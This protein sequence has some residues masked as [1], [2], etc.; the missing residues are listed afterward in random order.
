MKMSF[1]P[2]YMPPIMP[3]MVPGGALPPMNQPPPNF[4]PI[5]ATT[6]GSQPQM[7]PKPLP[8]PQQ[9][10]PEGPLITVFVGNISEKVP[11]TM[12]KRILDTCGTVIN[13]KR[14]STFGFCEYDGPIAG[15]RGVRLLNDLEIDG[16]KLVAKV[17]AKNK[18]LLDDYMEETKKDATQATLDANA[19]TERKDDT[20]ATDTIQQIIEEYADQIKKAAN[21]NEPHHK[22]HKPLATANIEEEKRDIISQEIGKFR[23]YTEEMEAKKEERKR[24]EEARQE[25]KDKDKDKEKEKQVTEE[26]SPGKRDKEKK[27]K[28]RS[29]SRSRGSKSPARS[30]KER[31]R[32]RSHSR[33]REREVERERREREI[34]RERRE[35]ELERER[36]ERELDAPPKV[37]KNLKELQRE[38]EIEEEAR[39][40]KKQEKKTR[41]KEAAYQDRLRNWES[42]ERRKTKEY[43]RE[44]ETARCKEEEREK[45]AKRLKEFLE[46][47]EDERDDPKYYKG[48]ELQR[49]LADRV[50]EA[51][52]DAKDRQREQEELEELKAKIFSG[53][54]DNPSLEFEKQKK[55]REELYK[56]KILVDANPETQHERELQREKERIADKLRAK[57]RKERYLNQQMSRNLEGMDAEPIES[58]DDAAV[59]PPQPLNSNNH[60]PKQD[61]DSRI[62]SH[63]GS[64]S[65]D[66]H[67]HHDADSRHSMESG[68]TPSESPRNTPNA[69]LPTFQVSLS[70][71]TNAKKKKLVSDVFQNDDD[72][73]EMN[74]PK[75]RKLVPLD[76]DEN[77][78]SKHAVVNT[79]A[80]AK[81][82]ATQMSSSKSGSTNNS[83]NKKDEA[84]SKKSDEEKRRHIKSIIDKIPTEKNL[85]FNY[86]LDKSEIDSTIEKKIRPWINKKIIEYIGEPEPTLVDFICSKVLA[87]STPQGILDDVQMVLD[88]EAEVFVVKMWRLLIYEVEAKKLGISK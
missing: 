64:E 54:Y 21:P 22:T 37:V 29:H 75:K 35:R 46:D 16:K 39:E 82:A 30:E 55:E 38:K 18:A 52:A 17:D 67:I 51:D 53:E 71:N 70:L 10:E 3:P 23:K 14:V 41:E 78:A 12:I 31:R 63:R 69:A 66:S 77:A 65:R 26:E 36:R 28:R 13:W 25:K 47:Y 44:R 62:S 5:G 49:R 61:L 27:S 7:Y 74:G 20:S 32:R 76:Y 60:S 59:T 50:R 58:D 19:A 79:H 6:I 57:E 73:E 81:A 15:A 33:S 56:P 43:D 72:Q 88:E 45:E 83:N 85:L 84:N 80:S 9:I 86:P 87:G 11:D 24:R 2:P 68:G 48:R 8:V 40:R 34:E 4:R 1:Q 42:R